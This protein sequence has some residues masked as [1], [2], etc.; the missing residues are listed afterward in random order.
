MRH[1]VGKCNMQVV[2]T[3]TDENPCHADIVFPEMVVANEVKHMNLA[4]YLANR[5]KLRMPK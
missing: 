3:P 1:V 5:S 2:S 4:Q